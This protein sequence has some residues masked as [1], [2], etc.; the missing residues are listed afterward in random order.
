[1]L[2][3]CLDNVRKNVPLVHNIT[4]Y[5]TVNDVANVLL[6]CGG[7]PI[8]SDEP[9]DV[10]DIT[11]IC[12]GLNINIGTLNK[13]SIEGMFLAGKKAN[14]LNHMVLLDPVGAGASKL[15]TDTAVK[16]MDEINLTVIRGNIS[17]I[18]TL[19]LGSGTTKGVDADVADAVS[20]DNLDD[21]VR[22][23]KEFAK[24]S[25]SVVAVTG[26]IDLVSDGEKCYVIRNGRPE[27]GKI[28]G[29]GCQLS[30]MMTAFLVANPDNILDAA[31]AAVCTMGF[32]GEI[33]WSNM[34]ETDGNSTFRNRI[35]DAIFNMDGEKL[36]DGAKFEVR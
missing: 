15:R 11:A 6:A 30:G 28:T 3:K 22:F 33:G 32:A 5:V 1:M 13:N 14:E 27:M 35:I 12:G 36:N 4:N 17:E 18:K 23:V 8:M 9:D 2:G 25:G 19:A 24:E 20:E 34:T 21:A 26:A 10:E 16:L 7:S 31:A 29:T